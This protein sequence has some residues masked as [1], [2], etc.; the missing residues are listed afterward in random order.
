MLQNSSLS[1]YID[2]GTD[3]E[4]PAC[5]LRCVSL[6]SGVELLNI[7][8]CVLDYNL[9]RVAIESEYDRDEVFLSIFD[10]PTSEL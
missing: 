10:P 9:M 4:V 3:M 1:K 5:Q 2:L 7:V 8:L 6:V